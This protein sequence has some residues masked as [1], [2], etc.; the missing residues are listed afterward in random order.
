MI[1]SE[2]AGI[3]SLVGALEHWRVLGEPVFEVL[4]LSFTAVVDTS[5]VVL[6][7][8]DK[9]WVASDFNTLGLV[10]SGVKFG[11]DEVLVVF[12]M[13][14][15]LIP[16]WSKLL[17]VTAPWGVVF[18]EDVLVLILDDVVEVLSN[19]DSECL[20]GVVNWLL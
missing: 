17:A 20:S 5:L 12:V 18:D 2:L 3:M 10:G 7:V 1:R 11:D 4:E 6:W 9:S 8:E 13:L 19:N 15:K 14:G 16:N